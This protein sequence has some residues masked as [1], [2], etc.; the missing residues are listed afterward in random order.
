MSLTRRA[1]AVGTALLMLALPAAGWAAVG[2]SSLGAKVGPNWS[3]LTRPDD[4]IGSPTLMHGTAFDG[5]GFTAGPAFRTTF[6]LGAS[7]GIGLEGD[8]LYSFHR[9]SGFQEDTRDDTRRT[10]VLT[11]HVLRVPLLATLQLGSVREGVSGYAGI[12]PELWQGLGTNATV[13][14]EGAPGPPDPLNTTR[15]THGTLNAVFGTTIPAGA[16]FSMPVEARVVWDPF[17]EDTTPERFAGYSSEDR[18][19]FYK[20]AFDW[21][22]LLMTGVSWTGF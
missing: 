5:F 8:L 13:E 3:R 10:A 7:L 21:Q 12:G 15:V 17:V 16:D 1:V 18:P 9:A 14:L 22:I 19:G 20:V 11:T 6:A 2:G 4:P